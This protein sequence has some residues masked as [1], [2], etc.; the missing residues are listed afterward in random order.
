MPYSSLK[1]ALNELET[2]GVIYRD[3]VQRG[4]KSFTILI[5][6]DTNKSAFLVG[7]T[8]IHYGIRGISSNG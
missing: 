8:G 4:P 3:S 7:H 5:L 2:E 6:R 1:V